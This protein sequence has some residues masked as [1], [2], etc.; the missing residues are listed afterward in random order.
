VLSNAA[1]KVIFKNSPIEDDK[2]A[3]LKK[4]VLT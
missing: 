4:F 1:K 3:T 2:E